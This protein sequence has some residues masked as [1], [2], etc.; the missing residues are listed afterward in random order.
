MNRIPGIVASF[1]ALAFLAGALPANAQY[2]NEFSPA[3]LL[4]QGSTT[5]DIAGT[6]TVIVQVQVNADGTHKA[7]KVIK[8]TNAGDNAAALD[9]AQN[10]TYRPAHRGTK[11]IP[12]FYDF[13][14]KFKG[15]R[16][17]S[18]SESGGGSSGSLSPAARQVAA[19]IAA[20]N[21]ASAKSK[22]QAALLSAPAD[23]TLR[24][25]LGIASLDAGD[26]VGSAEAFDKV[27][28]IG[29][30]F[31]PAAAA[32]F[33]A[34]AVSVAD[35]N[36]AQSLTFAQKAMAVN[37]DTN[38]RFALG[39]AQLANKQ[40]A[41]ALATL[42]AAHDAAAHDPK[43][44]T[45]AKVNIDARLMSAY[46]ANNDPAGAQT[47]AAEM[48][49]LDPASKLAG[50]VLGNT[51]LKQGVDA[52]T[53]GKTDEALK[54]FDM[55]AAQGDPEVAVTANVE[56]AFLLSKAQKADYKKMQSYADKA[57]AIKPDDPQANFAEGIALAGQAVQSHDDAM[58][59]KALD[60]L[61]KADSLA[62][63][64]GNEALAL[65]IETFIKTNLGGTPAGK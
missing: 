19:L 43:M 48:K 20:K 59:K 9:I 5:K 22:A 29:T 38:A 6:G 18:S 28:S 2:A 60:A 54:D 42:K 45:S 39:V 65:S 49:Q 52:S 55:A 7:T 50:R 44:S 53:A 4:K 34:A 21:Y 24:E 1:A 32:A 46:L 36:P 57:L 47:V 26:V 31:K 30:Q 37:P 61:N 8:S 56:A 58:K 40:N 23:Q 64:A 62:K 12:A 35:S 17:A 27:S 14:L 13:T 63:A 41:E 10:S 3:K 25:M 51:Y 33:A 16:V 15:K 11:P